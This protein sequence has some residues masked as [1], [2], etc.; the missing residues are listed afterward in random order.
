MNFGTTTFDEREKLESVTEER[1][2]RGA[3]GDPRGRVMGKFIKGAGGG[4]KG[5]NSSRTQPGGGKDVDGDGARGFSR[6]RVTI[7]NPSPNIA[8]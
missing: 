4:A 5:I 2:R 7:I 3:F 8:V 6:Q 1:C